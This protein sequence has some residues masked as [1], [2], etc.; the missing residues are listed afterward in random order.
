MS[1]PRY[2]VVSAATDRHWARFIAGNGREVWRTSETY[3]RRRGAVNA[4]VCITEQ[5]IQHD[6]DGAYVWLH[7]GRVE[8]RYVEELVAV[9]RPGLP[10]LGGGRA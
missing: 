10:D 2:E 1:G 7:E 5:F 3:K 9:E 6:D 4:V 8:V